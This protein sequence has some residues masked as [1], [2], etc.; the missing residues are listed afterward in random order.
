MQESRTN[1]CRNLDSSRTVQHKSWHKRVGKPPSDELQVIR[2]L[3]GTFTPSSC[4]KALPEER[5]HFRK[6]LQD[7]P[8][9]AT[10]KAGV[11]FS[12]FH[13]LLIGFSSEKPSTSCC[14]PLV[15][16]FQSG[17]T[18]SAL[19]GRRVSSLGIRIGSS[20]WSGTCESSVLPLNWVNSK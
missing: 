6:S 11:N 5:K 1:D 14:E 7:L 18:G 9:S 10:S 2:L 13:F 20:A 17:I 4:E 3:L 19:W 15:V 16:P 12:F 8:S